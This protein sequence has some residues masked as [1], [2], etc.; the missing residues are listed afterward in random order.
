MAIISIESIT[1]SRQQVYS[2]IKNMNVIHG[3][4]C[5]EP[6]AHLVPSQE[7]HA[8]LNP[9][10]HVTSDS[11]FMRQ[12]FHLVATLGN[13]PFCSQSAGWIQHGCLRAGDCCLCEVAANHEGVQVNRQLHNHRCVFGRVYWLGVVW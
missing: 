4:L 13:F 11:D 8:K 2:N 6:K 7:I 5:D 12:H 10:L 1:M 3:T 9:N